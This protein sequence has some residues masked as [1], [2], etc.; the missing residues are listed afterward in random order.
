MSPPA[1][2]GRAGSHEWPNVGQGARTLHRGSDGV[3]VTP[4]HIDVSDEVIADLR[5]RLGCT[6][7]PDEPDGAAWDWGT[8]LAYLR[9]LTGYWEASFDWR[10]QQR[11]LNRVPNFRA[12]I[13][14][15]GIHFIHVRGKGPS[16]FPLILTHGWPSTFYEY[17]RLIPLL[18]DPGAHG[19]DP[20]DAFDVVVPSL[21]GY[22]FSDRPTA[23]DVF[24]Q[25]PELWVELMKALGYD[26]FGAQGGDLGA[27]V[28]ARLGMYHPDKVVGVH[29]T[30]LYGSIE[31]GDPPPTDAERRYLAELDVW[32]ATEGAYREI[33]ATRP[34][35]LAFGLNDSPAGLAAW[36]IEK[37][38]A[39][40]DCGGD[41]E[42]VFTKDELL[43]NMT[44]YWITQTIGSSLRPYFEYRND[45]SP[46][47]WRID[48]PCAVA[49]FPAD[50][51]QPPREFA[52]RFY[53]V[54]Q[55]TEM[56]RGGHFAAFEAPDLLAQDIRTFFRTLRAP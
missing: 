27:D 34:Q 53:N 35:T 22:G 45:P 29:V 41:V 4:Y 49:V 23:R 48:V 6:R 1:S 11:A 52:E 28:S 26:C 31:E 18:A 12:H 30:T 32:Y 16:P 14:G 51:D 21:P 38:R 24:A 8:N 46:K 19:A 10:A 37:F 36:I 39:W 56:P 47:P 40:S 2:L 17:S 5:Y 13:D 25:I 15:L 54:H 55:W 33:Q 20:S 44:I 9:E 50:I 42:R 7:W 43:T 3:T